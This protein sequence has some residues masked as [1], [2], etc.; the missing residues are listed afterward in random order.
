M[1][2]DIAKIM[3]V[4]CGGGVSFWDGGVVFGI[5]FF[6]TVVFR[7]DHFQQLNTRLYTLTKQTVAL[8]QLAVTST[9]LHTFQCVV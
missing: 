1:S 7:W 5:F 3:S 2:T 8:T 6:T 4:F 9:L